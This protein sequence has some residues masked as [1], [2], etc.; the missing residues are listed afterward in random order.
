[1]P[2]GV[3]G[4]RPG[5]APAGHGGRQADLGADRGRRNGLRDR[6]RAPARAG[7]PRVPARPLVAG[8]FWSLLPV[9]HFLKRISSGEPAT[10]N[11]H[12]ACFV[13]DDP[14][15]RFSSYG[16]VSFPD[17]A[18]DARE[19]GYHVAVATIPLDLLLPGRGAVGVVR[20]FR[21][22]LSLAVHGNDHVYRELE[23]RRSAA[24]ADRLI[25]SAD[26]RVPRFEERAGISIERVMCP[27]HG[28]C[29]PETLAALFRCGFLGLAASRPFPWDGFA[30]QRRWRLGG[31]LPAQLAGGGLPVMP[32]YHLSR[33][34]DDL[35]FRAFLGQPLMVYCHHEDLC[36]GLEPLR[37]AA[38]RAA[39]VGDVRWMSLASIAGANA[40][41][42]EQD[43]VATVALHSRD[44][45]IPRPA[46]PTHPSRGGTPHSRSGRPGETG[47]GRRETRCAGRC[48][49]Q[50]GDRALE[51]ATGSRASDSALGAWPTSSRDE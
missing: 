28:G 14:N 19:C 37:A 16:C 30:D 31:W 11:A 22:E 33:H 29:G 18:R 49:R 25:L 7:G 48:R 21:S 24:E 42:R 32:R 10:P 5:L 51:P 27:P 3:R 26:A 13:I 15:L 44:L 40:L 47:G 23:R 17:L 41:F 36:D 39:E 35:V 43:G 2:A 46:A 4:R 8:R 12:N 9:V 50:C 34:P 6:E 20:T 1:M 45:R 38:A